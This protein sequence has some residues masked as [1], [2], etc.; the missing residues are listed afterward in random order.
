M[1]QIVELVK[2]LRSH[3]DHPATGALAL[4]NPDGPSAADA[5]ESQA[6]REAEQAARI[7]ELEKRLF[8]EDC[9][10]ADQERDFLA[11]QCVT[12]G[13][14]NASLRAKLERANEALEPFASLS[15]PEYVPDDALLVLTTT[16]GGII[17]TKET[18]TAG[19]IRTAHA[20][21]AELS[22]AA[23]AQQTPD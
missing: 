21:R 17:D 2:R 10:P 3:Q 1:T 22:A 7:A 19:A 6:A 23:P 13:K 16:N 14:E 15:V 8:P 5:L 11:E 12:L 9:P 4:R 20:V 18:V